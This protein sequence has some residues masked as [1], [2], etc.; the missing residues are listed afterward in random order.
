[1]TIV[2]AWNMFNH[3]FLKYMLVHLW[4]SW[5]GFYEIFSRIYF[6]NFGINQLIPTRHLSDHG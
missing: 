2:E 1:M 3:I 6:L 5:T 4:H